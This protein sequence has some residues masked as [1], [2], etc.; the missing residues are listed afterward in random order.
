MESLTFVGWQDGNAPD[1]LLLDAN[2][3]GIRTRLSGRP[4]AIASIESGGCLQSGIG[5]TATGIKLDLYSDGQPFTTP[6]PPA[7]FTP[8]LADLT[9]IEMY[10]GDQIHAI[11]DDC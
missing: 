10:A 1:A 8:P 9:V 5:H 3:L 7:N 6:D 4:E 2:G 11:F